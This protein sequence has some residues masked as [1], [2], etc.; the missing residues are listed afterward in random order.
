[1][2]ASYTRR[3]LN[4]SKWSPRNR[5]PAL[6]PEEVNNSVFNQFLEQLVEIFAPLL[7][8]IEEVTG[9]T[10]TIDVDDV[11]RHLRFTNV[12]GCT[13]TVPANVDVDIPVGARIRLTAAAA[14]D[15]VLTPAGGVTLNSRDDAF[16]S[17]GQYA[18]FEL[19]KVATDEWDCL[20]DLLP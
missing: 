10:Y 6:P 3:V 15:V 12:A 13:V 11:W 7:L 5:P 9:T 17:G 16:T 2:P 14:G 20:G 1:M 19:E 4:R 8:T 18:V